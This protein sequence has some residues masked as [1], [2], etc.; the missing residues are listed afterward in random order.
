ML[1]FSPPAVSPQGS[2]SVTPSTH[3]VNISNT[4]VF[5]CTANGGPNNVY[6]W[7]RNSQL[8]SDQTNPNIT[9]SSINSTDGGV[10][11]CNVTNAAGSG[12]A[13]ATLVVRPYIVVF[14]EA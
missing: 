3:V 4:A 14:P 9:I 13:M 10:Y 2:V 5:S 7:Y 8:L 1:Y 12:V 11:T 6:Q